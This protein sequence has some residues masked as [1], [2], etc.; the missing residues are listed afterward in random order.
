MVIHGKHFSPPLPKIKNELRRGQRVKKKKKVV[1]AQ[2]K[3]A[4]SPKDCFKLRI[5]KK[6]KND[7][8]H[9]LTLFSFSFL[10]NY[11]NV[12]TLCCYVFFLFVCAFAL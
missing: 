12:G 3:K 4:V 10:F 9:K 1:R 7:G 6:K 5:T 2:K 8:I 11:K